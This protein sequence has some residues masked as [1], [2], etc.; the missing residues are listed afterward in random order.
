M[1]SQFQ[2]YG[3]GALIDLRQKTGLRF[4]DSISNNIISNDSVCICIPLIAHKL[5]VR[6]YDWHP[7]QY[8]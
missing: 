2:W 4:V 5:Y 8:T 1:L 7:K 3:R 6:S